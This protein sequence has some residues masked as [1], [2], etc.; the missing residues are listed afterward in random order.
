MSNLKIELAKLLIENEAWKVQ[1]IGEIEAIAKKNKDVNFVPTS[2]SDVLH[3]LLNYG[4]TALY[5]THCDDESCLLLEPSAGI[6]H[7]ANKV[8]EINSLIKI[9]VCEADPLFRESLALQGFNVVGAD[10]LKGQ[11]DRI[12]MNP[13]FSPAGVSGDHIKFCFENL[14]KKGGFL[15]AVCEA[16]LFKRGLKKDVA[17]QN[18]FKEKGGYV[19][20]LP[21]DAFRNKESF[22]KVAVVTVIAWIE[23]PTAIYEF[24]RFAEK[25]G[26]EKLKYENA[27]ASY[28]Y[29]LFGKKGSKICYKVEWHGDEKIIFYN[30]PKNY[31]PNN[32]MEL[33]YDVLWESIDFDAALEYLK[34]IV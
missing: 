6:G 25:Q 31:V 18:W 1:R 29:G 33:D 28:T 10:K 32:Y 8:R 34:K 22:K 23:K 3:K 2:D 9:D 17:F 16:N 5:G 19:V 21:Q 26:F 24:Q 12:L 30:T 20:K 11:Y 14:L 7:I 27:P 4:D 15:A 13:P